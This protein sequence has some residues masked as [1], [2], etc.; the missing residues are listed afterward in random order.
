M[1]Q[2]LRCYWDDQWSSNLSYACGWIDTP[3]SR[4]RLALNRERVGHVNL[5]WQPVERFSTGL[6]SMWGAQRVQEDARGDAAHSL[7]V[8]EFSL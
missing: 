5:I 6:E 8:S 3:D 1:F 4:V 7:F 2:G